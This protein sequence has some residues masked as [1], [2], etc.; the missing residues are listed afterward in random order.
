MDIDGA[1]DLI[2]TAVGLGAGVLFA[3]MALKFTNDMTKQLIED[4]KKQGRKRRKTTAK[5]KTT[6][7][8]K[9]R[10]RY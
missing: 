6:K 9:R 10:T 7:N 1:T 5:R 2:G 8:I 4:G 3:G